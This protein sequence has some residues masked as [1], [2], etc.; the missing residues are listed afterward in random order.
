MGIG[1][2]GS[3]PVLLS[4]CNEG[5]D[6]DQCNQYVGGFYRHGLKSGVLCGSG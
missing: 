1:S 3:A 5:L 2:P 4:R 6:E